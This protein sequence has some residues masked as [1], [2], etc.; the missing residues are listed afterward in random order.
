MDEISL[1]LERIGLG[2]YAAVFLSE[3][4]DLGVLPTLTDRDLKEL[5]LSLGHRRTLLGAIQR[6][7]AEPAAVRPVPF[8][9]AREGQRRQL[10]LLFCDIV[11]STRLS[12]RLDPED[13]RAVIGAYR[14]ACILPVKRFGG[15]VG[16]L[17]GDGVLAYFGY[18]TAHEDDAERAVRAGLGIVAALNGLDVGF[19]ADGALK[20]A[21]RIGIATGFVVV[22]DML[23]IGAPEKDAVVGEAPNLASRLQALAEPGAIVIAASTKQL[24]GDRFKCRDLGEQRLKGIDKPAHAWQV[25]GENSENRFAARGAR[26]SP[27]VG[28]TAELSLL[29]ERWRAAA[30][31]AGQVALLRGDAGIGKSRIVA[32]ARAEIGA[33]GGPASARI[34]TFQCSPFHSNS[35]LHPIAEEL[36]RLS[37]LRRRATEVDEA[38]PASADR[39]TQL[40]TAI[41]APAAPS[42]SAPEKRRRT[43]DAIVEWLGALAAERPLLLLF[44]DLQWLDPTSLLLLAR[45]VDWA[46]DRR[47]MIIGTLR[48]NGADDAG[49]ADR[50]APQ[51]AGWASAAHVTIVDLDELTD[52]QSAEL[53]KAVA[54][55]ELGAPAIEGLLR[56][57][58]GNPLYIEELTRGWIESALEPGVVDID[59]ARLRSAVGIPTTLMDA[60]MA[61]LDRAGAALEVAQHAA[62]IG[63]SFTPGFLA[64]IS[65]LSP[66]QIT[67]GLET[68]TRLAIL[69]R[70][71]DSAEP[72]L[73]FKHALLQ[74]AAYRSLLKSRRRVLH[75]KIAEALDRRRDGARGDIDTVI[76]EH[77]ALGG[78]PREAVSAWSRAAEDAFARSA[79]V[80]AANLLRRATAALDGVVDVAER[81]KLELDLTLRL[82][83][84]LR[85]I[86]GYAARVAEEQYAKARAL[87]VKTGVATGRFN[88]EWGLLQCAY[89]KGDMA[90]AR[91]IADGLFQHARDHPDRP[92]VDAHLA[93]GMVSFQL[94]ELD[95]ARA[96]FEQG[97][98]I[99]RRETDPP[100]YF[101]HGQ[102]PGM[103]CASFLAY[104]LW[105]L[106]E[107]DRA[108]QLI[109]ENLRIARARSHEPSHV[110]SFVS[111]LTYA[112]RLHQNWRETAQ[113]RRFA[114]ELR[115]VS[116]RNHYAYY[117]ALATAHLA[118]ANSADQPS[119]R[120]IGE[121]R[122]AIAAIIRTGTVNTLTGFYARLAELY[123]RVGE[124][125]SAFRTLDRAHTGRCRAIVFWDV[126]IERIRG[127][128]FLVAPSPDEA[129]AAA[130]FRA[131]L[132]LAERQNARA[133]GLRS[134]ISY[135]RL[136]VRQD[137]L[138]DAQRLLE[139]ALG[140]IVAECDAPDIVEARSL[141]ASIGGPARATTRVEGAE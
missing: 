53:L 80:E 133:L 29:S 132:A 112:A 117:E 46:R 107:F 36:D 2:H 134:A 59:P 49:G 74:D 57:A 62:A 102:N 78:A 14:L 76:A 94:G 116:Q 60:L 26:L 126:E 52:T 106:G 115:T 130:C 66:A 104:T 124:S 128:A 39:E 15:Y 97:L 131:S 63:D 111:V 12:T 100:H 51:V 138:R 119:P 89:V 73:R 43:L 34:L 121:M 28:R 88:I 45:L 109:T 77:Y 7:A 18:P 140:G 44:E 47:A 81:A 4:I 79:Q 6:L 99:S 48:T 127:E 61:R 22:G 11:D 85:S 114:E 69:T 87:A 65:T 91:S 27:L 5:G 9:P 58:Q 67:E 113:T 64:A 42:M 31:G 93:R 139:R 75:L 68:L 82:A 135:A 141:A 3:N 70:G 37:T 17:V 55:G 54:G 103:F 10:T 83:A 72:A 122:Q 33:E 84:A 123:L 24:I 25:L 38:S 108:H 56:K 86:H 40:L 8:P 137:R 101:T 35:A 19:G 21:V 71:A 32:S 96:E 98:E 95:A 136:L 90:S 50:I 20:L 30:S 16:R 105:F 110:H 92:Y 1:W 120:G 23:D 118:W 129:A 41:M 125:A 13:L